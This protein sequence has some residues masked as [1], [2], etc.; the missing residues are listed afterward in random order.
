MLHDAGKVE[1]AQNYLRRWVSLHPEDA[2]TRRMLEGQMPGQP[3][4]P[5]TPPTP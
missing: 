1:E 5:V 4:A 3:S 2:E